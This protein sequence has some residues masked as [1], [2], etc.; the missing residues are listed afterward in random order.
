M[1]NTM[2]QVEQLVP[3]NALHRRESPEQSGLTM[4]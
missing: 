4:K 3:E 2:T 1:K